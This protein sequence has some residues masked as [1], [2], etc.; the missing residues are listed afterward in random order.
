MCSVLYLGMVILWMVAGVMI[1]P[2]QTLYP[3]VAIATYVIYVQ[4]VI[5]RANKLREKLQKNFLKK[6]RAEYADLQHYYQRMG[7]DTRTLFIQLCALLGA[8]ALLVTWILILQET[9]LASGLSWQS[10]MSTLILPIVAGAKEIIAKENQ[11]KA[12]TALIENSAENTGNT[13]D[14]VE[15]A[16][17]TVDPFEELTRSQTSA[18]RALK[19]SDKK[20]WTLEEVMLWLEELK[21]DKAV[22]DQVEK[23]NL[24]GKY[25]ETIVAT[26]NIQALIDIGLD[27]AWKQN[28]IMTDW[29]DAALT[30]NIIKRTEAARLLK[31]EFT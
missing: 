3:I 15:S 16:I 8:I 1:K 5:D 23:Q 24:E 14:V 18:A 25:F 2:Q 11:A 27:A 12:V 9:L 4:I 30:E 6:N 19:G 10:L 22:I 29:K 17:D 13:I 20:D 26:P 28:K 31:T 21:Y 7:L